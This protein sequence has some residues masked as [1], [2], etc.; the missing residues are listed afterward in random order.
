MA[1]CR[2]SSGEKT[3]PNKANVRRDNVFGAEGL[4]LPQSLRSFAMTLV[5]N[6]K[7]QSQSVRK[8]LPDRC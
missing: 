1:I 8:E 3:K 6:L 5:G 7:K 2:P 4:R